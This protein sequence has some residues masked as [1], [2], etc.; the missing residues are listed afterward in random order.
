ME[1][2]R[3]Y[4]GLGLAL[5]P[6]AWTLR[7]LQGSVVEGGAQGLNSE[8]R[9]ALALKNRSPQALEGGVRLCAMLAA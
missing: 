2:P 5:N 6:L 7:G 1:T 8:K 4:P 9:E 3:I